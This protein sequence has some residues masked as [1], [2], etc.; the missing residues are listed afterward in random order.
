[1]KSGYNIDLANSR[2]TPAACCDD[3]N[4]TKSQSGFYVTALPVRLADGPAR[5]RE[6]G[7]GHDLLRSGGHGSAGNGRNADSIGFSSWTLPGGCSRKRASSFARI[8]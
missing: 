8:A 6:H 1:M 3:C 4:G 2:A 5:V 7:R